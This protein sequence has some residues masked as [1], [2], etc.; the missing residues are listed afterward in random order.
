MKKY[1]QS[2]RKADGWNAGD[3]IVRDFSALDGEEFSIDQAITIYVSKQDSGN[4]QE[5]WMDAL[6]T[7]FYPVNLHKPGIALRH[8]HM[9]DDLPTPV[10]SGTTLFQSL[11]L[12]PRSYGQ[13]LRPTVMQSD[14]FYSLHELFAFIASSELRFLSSITTKLEACFRAR[15]SDDAKHSLLTQRNLGYYH[16]LLG[17]HF[18]R[19]QQTLNFI[20][21]RDTLEW[22]KSHTEVAELAAARLERDFEYLLEETRLLQGRCKS[23]MDML[24]NDA[25]MAEARR[26][27]EQGQKATKLTVLATI[28]IPLA[29]T[30]SLFGMNF[31]T[32]SSNTRGL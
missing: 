31:V 27:L 10:D 8:H 6:M 11:S 23:E 13:S 1:T 25:A 12:L 9:P 14:V 28:F 17:T 3:S 2:L 19:T 5:K 21:S 22:P 16:Y 32:F 30:S 20:K 15:M 26:N 7:T 18:A 24:T 29:F 4:N